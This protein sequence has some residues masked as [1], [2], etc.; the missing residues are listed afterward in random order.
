M[1]IILCRI[2]D[3]MCSD[4][5]LSNKHSL[6]LNE[7][8]KA[9]KL[10]SFIA[11]KVDTNGQ[12]VSA[13]DEFM[14]SKNYIA[15]KRKEL[16]EK[17]KKNSRPRKKSNATTVTGYDSTDINEENNEHGFGKE[18]SVSNLNFETSGE[19]RTHNLPNTRRGMQK[20]TKKKRGQRTLIH[21]K[22]PFKQCLAQYGA[23]SEEPD[24]KKLT[25]CAIRVKNIGSQPCEANDEVCKGVKNDRLKAEQ[26]LAN[27]NNNNVYTAAQIEVH[28]GDANV[29]TRKRIER[30]MEANSRFNLTDDE[31][32]RLARY[33]IYGTSTPR[34]RRDMIKLEQEFK[35]TNQQAKLNI[36]I[37]QYQR[38]KNTENARRT[39]RLR[40]TTGHKYTINNINNEEET[41]EKTDEE[42][43]EKTDKETDEE[44]R[45]RKSNEAEKVAL[46]NKVRYEAEREKGAIQLQRVRRG[47]QNRRRVRNL[48]SA[49]KVKEQI[50]N[51]LAKREK[52]E[53]DEE[54][55][56]VQ[57][58]IKRDVASRR[59][60]SMYK[61]RLKRKATAQ[62]V[63]NVKQQN[64]RNFKLR[65]ISADFDVQ[66]KKRQ[67]RKNINNRANKEK[68]KSKR[69]SVRFGAEIRLKERANA[70]RANEARHKERERR[71]LNTQREANK[72]Q[73]RMTEAQNMARKLRRNQEQLKIQRKNTTNVDRQLKEAEEVSKEHREKHYDARSRV[74]NLINNNGETVVNNAEPNSNNN[75]NNYSAAVK[76]V[77]NTEPV[78]NTKT[79]ANTKPAKLNAIKAAEEAAKIVKDKKNNAARI[80]YQLNLGG[81]AKL[82]RCQSV[83]KSTK[84][85]CR[86]TCKE[87]HC[88]VHYQL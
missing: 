74:T 54:G 8:G 68:L 44:A 48:R 72:H 19:R 67:E 29:R 76:T 39:A 57:T 77:D 21:P 66:R 42:T 58:A 59:I 13:N 43:D 6:Y 85:R 24:K 82:N 11:M 63:Q 32:D 75:N 37:R 81:G 12:L 22:I 14:S 78:A 16:K 28:K 2:H 53:A 62:K 26:Y 64:L 52:R 55:N 45:L 41:D 47:Y 80:A 15:Y 23:N 10:P 33:K 70:F 25:M 5:Q 38:Q 7:E 35:H 1:G 73:N 87:K 79:V 49:K 31:L 34:E 60:G 30:N 61:S 88:H 36:L 86:N 40:R 9:N 27:M 46:L 17:G 84:K 56:R 51:I 4:Q 65:R 3:D 71:A 69:M 18:Y 83:S 50:A 20:L